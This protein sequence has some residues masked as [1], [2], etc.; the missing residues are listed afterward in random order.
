MD[1]RENRLWVITTC[2]KHADTIGPLT[3]KASNPFT[4]AL[5]TMGYPRSKVHFTQLVPE[6]PPKGQSRG[7]IAV[8]K[9]NGTAQHYIER[10]KDEI[11]FYKPNLVLGLGRDV[12]YELLGER[13]L[14]DWRGHIVW[15]EDLGTKVLCTYDPFHAHQQ[16]QA[17]KRDKPGQ[18]KALML[19][20]AKKACLEAGF[21]GTNFEEPTLLVK[22]SFEE[23]KL[24]L[25]HMLNKGKVLSY[26]IEITK[27]YEAKLM[28]C[29]GLAV[30][31]DFAISVPFWD[32][33]FRYW[34]NKDEE[35][36]IF[37]LV[38]R[39]LESD[40]PKVAQHSQFDSVILEYFYGINVRNVMWDTMV[41]QHEL[42]CD[43]PKDLGTLISLYTKL[44]YHKQEIHIGGSIARWEY[45]AKDATANLHVMY[46]QMEEISD[47]DDVRL[48]TELDGIPSELLETRILKHYYGIPN[49]ALPVCN[50]LQQEGV[51]ISTELR[52]TV[53][54]R[55]RTYKEQI[56]TAL[57][58]ALAKLGEFNPISPAQKQKLFYGILHCPV[59]TKKGVV[60]L[61]KN[62]MKDIA[63]NDNREYVR[64][65]AKACL[66]A[67]AADAKVLKF[68]VEPDNGRIRTKYDLCGTDTGRLASKGSGVLKAETNLQNIS[69]GLQR[70]MIIAQEGEELAHV[71]LYA[72]E[73]YL[74]Y[75]DAGELEMLR[76]ISALNEEPE[77][78]LGDETRVLDASVTDRY[79]VHGWMQ[80]ITK[81]EFPKECEQANYTYKKAKQTIHGLHYGVAPKMMSLES[82]LPIYVTEWQ[83]NMYHTKYPGVRK[84]M[85]RIVNEIR[86]GKTI[87]S[88]L[89]R[90]RMF[91]MP[92]NDK[93]FKIAYATPSQSAIGEITI[94]AMNYLHHARIPYLCKVTL[95]THDGLAIR[96]K[97][98]ERDKVIPYI[99]NA[100]R[101]PITIN[102][103]TI[104]IPVSIGWGDNFDE[105]NEEKV[106]F[107]NDNLEG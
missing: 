39:L 32:D 7:G 100:Y 78:I 87:Y 28:D 37:N 84:R 105:N 58:K 1:T 79:K 73:A 98:G 71:D 9:K 63:E 20:D 97:K 31:K 62:A 88:P 57:N 22:P 106:Y 68:L 27:P 102:G 53:L 83:Y 45:N 96:T 41:I 95:N 94:A 46:G 60:T 77:A 40:I 65:L 47:I 82:G 75:L 55:E 90:R 80:S 4:N 56:L 15:S 36:E 93:L 19:F 44:P 67:K 5:L 64:L 72:A 61:D 104:H 49:T 42:Y 18:Y 12:L 16:L 107:Y 35:L 86:R 54:T 59:H 13:N 48:P 52:E 85:V 25:T 17:D 3:S 76:Y 101:V 89:G 14:N 43:L 33:G 74:I 51:L 11:R 81:Q 69:S 29:I 30:S 91:L 21:A 38:K 34:K 26:D 8:F 10:L 6:L 50:H 92:V 24:A 2:K 23:A 99:L 103:I 66:E 70:Q